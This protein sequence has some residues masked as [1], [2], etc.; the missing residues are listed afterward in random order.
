MTDFETPV[1]CD[2]LRTCQEA[3]CVCRHAADDG[4][5]TFYPLFDVSDSSKTQ[6]N[7]GQSAQDGHN[8]GRF[9]CLKDCGSAKPTCTG[10]GC[11]TQAALC[12]LLEPHQQSLHHLHSIHGNKYG[13]T[14]SRSAPADGG[15]CKH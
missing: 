7:R 9:V 2:I 5:H 15:S 10:V 11:Q 14:M 1:I 3:R 12:L 8:V 6:S 4:N 13:T